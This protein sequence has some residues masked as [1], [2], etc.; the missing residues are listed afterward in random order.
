LNDNGSVEPDEF[1]KAIEKIGIMIPTK[2]DVDA[3]FS[4]YDA[5]GSGAI[6]YKEFASSLYGRPNTAQSQA[7][8]G[9]RS[10]E[11]LAESL[12]NK[13]ISRGARGFIGL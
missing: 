13:L 4:V 11:E 5:D 7:R 2:Q 3:L 9:A 6:T 1:A 8:A 10:P 12:R